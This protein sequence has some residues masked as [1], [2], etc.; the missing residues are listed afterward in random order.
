MSY[1][2]SVTLLAN[3]DATLGL[4]FGTNT[5][6]YIHT[7]LNFAVALCHALAQ[8]SGWWE[9][10]DTYAGDP[11]A[12]RWA[13]VAKHDLIHSEL[14]EALEAMRKG[15]QDDHLP[16]RPG[17]EVELADAVI[18]I[19]DLA[20]KMNL[21]LPG[22]LIEKLAYNQQRPDHKKEARAAEGG[23]TF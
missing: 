4:G 2:G 12:F 3:H 14:S 23:K 8:H 6:H 21:D 9:K 13:L 18:R 20:G 7:G 15:L 16:N 10:E 1:V 11:T 5:I 17:V 19:F 22:A